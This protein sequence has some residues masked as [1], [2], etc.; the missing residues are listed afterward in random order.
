MAIHRETMFNT[1]EAF[2]YILQEMPFITMNTARVTSEENEH[3]NSSC[4]SVSHK[5]RMQTYQRKMVAV[6]RLGRNVC[7]LQATVSTVRSHGTQS[8]SPRV[9]P[10]MLRVIPRPSIWFPT[11]GDTPGSLCSAHQPFTNLLSSCLALSSLLKRFHGVKRKVFPG[12]VP[13]EIDLFCGSH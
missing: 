13:I 9:Q 3:K 7:F 12:Q 1:R 11:T 6:S 4:G 2:L 5:I 8:A 10:S